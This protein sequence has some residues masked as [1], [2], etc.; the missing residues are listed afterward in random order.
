MHDPRGFGDALLGDGRPAIKL[1]AM[2]LVFA[3]AFALF[4]T[5]VRQFLPHDIAWLGMSADEVCALHGCRVAAFMFHDRASFGGTLLA[6]GLLYLWLAEFPLRQRQAWAWWALAASGT[7]G[8]LSFLAY[9]GYGYLDGW[10]GVGTL[11]LLPCWMLGMWRVFPTLEGPR[12]PAALLRPAVSAGLRT[13]YGAGRALMLATAAGMLAGGSAILVLGMTTV[14]VPQDL[15]FM[16][17]TRDALAAISPRLIPLIAH[18]RAGFGGAL[19]SCAVAVAAC[20]WCGTPGRALWQALAMAGTFGFGCAFGV[21]LV[22]GYVDF[23]HLAPAG[24]GTVLFGAAVVTL[25]RPMV[26]GTAAPQSAT[27]AV[28]PATP[29]GD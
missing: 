7:L 4:L 8:F 22:V 14:F 12:G 1:T 5:A 16:G 13:R 26:A 11:F 15:H 9:L 19:V 23:T 3:G 18:D 2:G 28:A 21:H 6:I 17:A 25:W 20:A 27:V 29:A 24:A 10:H